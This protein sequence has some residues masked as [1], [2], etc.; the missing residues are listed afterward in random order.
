[1]LLGLCVKKKKKNSASWRR[2]PKKKKYSLDDKSIEVGELSDSGLWCVLQV[3]LLYLAGDRVF[4]SEDEVYLLKRKK[5][6]R[7]MS[8]KRTKLRE[9]CLG[10]RTR[11]I[12]TEHD[13]P[14]SL[15]LK[16]LPAVL[17]PIFEELEIATTA[18][19]ALLVLDFVL[20]D[21]RFGFEVDGGGE[22]CRDGVVGGFGLGDEAMVVRDDDNFGC[23]DGP[24][25]H[26]AES[27]TTH[28]RLLGGF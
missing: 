27:F 13:H 11:Q 5:E 6:R 22:G 21:E 2:F 15:I 26:V 14:R 12:R 20:D 24:F 28:E 16:L 23:F 17:E 1:V 4:V 7:Q 19:T 8:G 3:F 25:A 18:I 10:T 9:T